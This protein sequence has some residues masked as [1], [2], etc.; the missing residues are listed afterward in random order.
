[1]IDQFKEWARAHGFIPCVTDSDGR[2]VETT[3][4]AEGRVIC[5]RLLAGEEGFRSD[6]GISVAIYP[7][8]ASWYS[9]GRALRHQGH[10]FTWETVSS[11]ALSD[12]LEALEDGPIQRAAKVHGA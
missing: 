1:M 2:T 5:C 4:G 6:A 8:G 12:V 7:R 9:V 10:A 11:G 3:A